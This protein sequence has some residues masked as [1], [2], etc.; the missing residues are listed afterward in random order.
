M[1]KLTKFL[2]IIMAIIAFSSGI[3]NIISVFI[4][5][6]PQSYAVL[7]ITSFIVSWAI[8]QE[9]IDND[10]NELNEYDETF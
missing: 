1:T 5:P 9:I 2:M 6:N 10:E 3:V 7:G 8:S 4:L